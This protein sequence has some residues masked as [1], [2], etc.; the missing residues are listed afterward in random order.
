MIQNE[1]IR[2]RMVMRGE[3]ERRTIKYQDAVPSKCV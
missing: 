1:M 3:M 2:E